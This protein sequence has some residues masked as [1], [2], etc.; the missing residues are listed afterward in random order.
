M[1]VLK[2]NLINHIPLN[3]LGNMGVVHLTV[4]GL[5]PAG[6]LAHFA[7]NW[8]KITKDRWVLTTIKR[9]RMEFHSTPYQDYEP[10]PPMF[11]LEQQHFDRSGST[12]TSRQGGGGSAE[13]GTSGELRLHLIPGTKEGWRSETGHQSKVPKRI[14]GVPSLQ[15]GRY[16]DLQEPHKTRRLASEGGLEG[17][18]FFGPNPP[19]SQE[20]SVFQ[21]GRTNIPVHMPPLRPDLSTMGLYQ[22]PKADSSSRTGAGLPSSNIHR[23]YTADGRVEGEGRRTGL[24]PGIF[25]LRCLGFTIN[26]EKTV[27]VPTQTLEFLGF[28]VNTVSME[29][30]LPTE[31]LKKIRAESRKLLGEG[32]ISG[33]A[34]SRLCERLREPIGT[35]ND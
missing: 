8:E 30:S 7:Q 2:E 1:I 15:N 21:T 31:K 19:R 33:R 16:T 4:T 32:L 27:L 18:V 9:Y 28:T 6:R 29:L 23:R 26:T 17:R 22:D 11:N 34:L 25:L 12:K 10:H 13:G 20:I 5:S 35:N 14:C 3:I 24:G